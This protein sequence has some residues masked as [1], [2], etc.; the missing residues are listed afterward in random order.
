MP[1]TVTFCNSLLEIL[2]LFL[3][4]LKVPSPYQVLPEPLHSEAHNRLSLPVLS[5][6]AGFWLRL[7]PSAQLSA[8]GIGWWIFWQ[9]QTLCSGQLPSPSNGIFSYSFQHFPPACSSSTSWTSSHLPEQ[10]RGSGPAILGIRE[11]RS[12]FFSCRHSL[13]PLVQPLPSRLSHHVL[14]LFYSGE[15]SF[16]LLILLRS[17]LSILFSPPKH[18]FLSSTSNTP[19]IMS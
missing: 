18:S 7:L 12:N 11:L 3:L 6:S 19:S 8:P 2:S 16:S 13:I 5:C 17:T 10:G 9:I 15:H 4:S 1:R 14:S